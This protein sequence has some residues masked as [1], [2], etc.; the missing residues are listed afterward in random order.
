MQQLIDDLLTLSSL[1]TDSPP[2]L[3]IPSMLPAC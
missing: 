3:K 1:E 2:P